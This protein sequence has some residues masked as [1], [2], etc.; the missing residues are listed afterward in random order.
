MKKSLIRLSVACLAFSLTAQAQE[1][2]ES[3][4][5]ET[6]IHGPFVGHVS[7]NEAVLWMRTSHGGNYELQLREAQPAD[8][9]PLSVQA[10]ALEEQDFCV[11]WRAQGLKAKTRYSYSIYAEEA[12]NS[13][14][15]ELLAG[16]YS[17][18]TGPEDEALGPVR[19]AFGSCADEDQAT[20]EVWEQI[21]LAQSDAIVLMGDTPYI[22][23]TDLKRQRQ[24]YQEFAAHP[25]MAKVLHSTPWYGTWDDHDFGQDGATGKLKG[26]QGARQV[27]MEYHANP[28]Y[29]EEDEGVYMS[30]R[31]GP[32]ETYVLDT[33]WF[34]NTSPSIFDAS[35]PT[36][37]GASQWAWLEAGLRNS[38][39]PVKVIVSGMIY[40][41]AVRPKK[42]DHWGAYPA[43]RRALFELIGRH[44]IRGVVLVS[45][46]IHRSRVIRHATEATAGYDILELISSPMHHRIITSANA[47]HPGL[48][49][50][51][52]LK[53]S[54]LQLTVNRTE[55]ATR[56][57]ARFIDRSGTVAFEIEIP[58]KD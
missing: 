56:T 10:P 23:S 25:P 36:L 16:P 17:F 58:T 6:L 8:A 40:N 12:P 19:I 48:I 21:A 45:G 28:L 50:D 34:A 39:A 5:V 13:K 55:S 15:E 27:F 51:M 38:N 7:A 4:L 18:T 37:L 22:D 31:R 49:W 52:G 20:G 30:F 47:P 54:F 43:E 57:T 42:P 14:F 46:D 32:V 44:Q 53:N 2:P 33:R 1:A 3:S 24:R 35:Q 9:K 41:D 29:G 26:K 11:R